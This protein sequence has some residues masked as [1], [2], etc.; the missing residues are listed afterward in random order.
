M[1]AERPA[2]GQLSKKK[3]SPAQ[4]KLI[5]LKIKTKRLQRRAWVLEKHLS[6]H[7]PKWKKDY[8]GQARAGMTNVKT[9]L[10]TPVRRADIIIRK[11]VLNPS[12]NKEVRKVIAAH[13]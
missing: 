8:S 9:I 6:H 10:S 1:T 12:R 2:A 13:E 5:A 11:D 3:R 7:Y 4:K